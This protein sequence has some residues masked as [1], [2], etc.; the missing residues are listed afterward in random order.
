MFDYLNDLADPRLDPYRDLKQT[1]RTRWSGTFIAE[2]GKLVERLLASRYPVESILMAERFVEAWRERLPPAL[3]VYVLPDT[4]VEQLVG[5]NFHRGVLACGRRIAEPTLAEL[6]PPPKAVSL[7]VLPDVQSPEN[8]GV[9]LRISAALGVD[10]IILGPR[11]GD[12]LSR[13][14]LRTS[15]GYALQ[16]PIITLREPLL[17]LDS[18]KTEHQVTLIATAL[19]PRAIDLRSLQPSPRQAIFFGSEGHGLEA[20]YLRLCQHLV[21][22]PMRPGIDSLN[23][24]VAA[25][26]V[27]HHLLPPL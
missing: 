13:R 20:D 16:V 22:I 14:V 17:A 15:M 7:V 10:A 25:G 27:L 4:L 24:G 2:G 5:F 8:L 18:L 12:P 19:D 6:V 11:A 1:N 9:I 3:P 21:T 23:V 26:I